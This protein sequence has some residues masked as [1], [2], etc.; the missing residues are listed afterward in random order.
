MLEKAT[1]I[2]RFE[3]MPLCS[4]LK[5][6]IDNVK[7]QYKLSK[8]Q[9]YNVIDDNKEDGDNKEEDM[10]GKSKI[11]REFDA[12]LEDIRNNGRA[13]KS[14]SVKSHGSNI[15][16]NLLIMKLLN[17]GKTL[18]KKYYGFDHACNIFVEIDNKRNKL[19]EYKPR[20]TKNYTNNVML[21][22]LKIMLFDMFST[23]S[24]TKDMCMM[25]NKKI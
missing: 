22:S 24:T 18:L 10:S 1:T 19:C 12:I 3:Y 13:T 23:L 21:E 4:E 7:D 16:L 20:D 2:K 8:D 25:I 5:K 6:Q 9:K 17:A 11:T 14:I 15:T